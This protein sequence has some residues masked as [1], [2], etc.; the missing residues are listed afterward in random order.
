VQYRQITPN[1]ASDFFGLV[2][3]SRHLVIS[4]HVSVDD[5][6][7]ASVLAIFEIISQKYP[8]KDMRILYS[9]AADTKY[10]VFKD[11]AKIEFVQDIADHLGDTDLL[12]LL[13]GS[14]YSRFSQKEK[15]LRSIPQTI[16]LDHHASPID[17]FTLSL[18]APQYPS[19][20]E[21][22][23]RSLFADQKIDK[24]LAEI[25]L[26]GILGDTGNFTYLKSTQSDS[27]TIAK[28]LLDISQIEIQEFQSRYKT[29]SQRVLSL[30]S[31]LVKNTQYSSAKNWPNFQYSFIT[32]SFMTDNQYTENE[33]SDASHL[34]SAQYIRTVTGY[35]WGF[36]ITPKNNGDVDISCRSL[37]QCVNVRDL[38]ERMGL[39]GGH[40]R[41]S[42]GTFTRKDQPLAVAIC[43]TETLNWIRSNS[44]VL[45]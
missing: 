4:G 43:L 5:D 45:G 20:S 19:C 7:I 32:R 1:F 18:I 15:L 22:I 3:K 38:M 13:D 11:F 36:V 26:L 2:D 40:D 35:P 34:Y 23:Y 8:G 39:G 6:S 16:C 25:F 21:V 37:P 28:K 12:I 30:I 10:S 41:A 42:G 33:V 29:I 24:P 9:N 17:D 14:T 44:P 31:E 27:L